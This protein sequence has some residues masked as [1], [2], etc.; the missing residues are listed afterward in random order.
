MATL[1]PLVVSALLLFSPLAALA[2]SKAA[3]VKLDPQ[4]SLAAYQGLVEDHLGGVL[5]TVRVLA[6]SQEAMSAKWSSVQPLLDRFGKDLP[7]DAI[8]WYA[9]PDGRYYSTKTGRLTDQNLKDRAYFPKLLSGQD[10]MGDLVIS[11]STGM[12]SI[13]V[14]SPVTAKGKVV[15]AI[16]V[17]VGADLLAALVE[18]NTKLPENTYF[19]ALTSDT[20][21]ALHRYADRMFKTVSDVGDEQLGDAFKAVM[22][23]ERGVFDYELNGRKMNAIFSRSQALGWHFFIAQQKK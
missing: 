9:L 17:S 22:N 5:R 2:G 1:I 13:V 20:R 8:V 12:R 19:Y 14:A 4:V 21:I 7:T 16:G 10:V 6:G 23:S 11:K 3:A 18:A 15:G